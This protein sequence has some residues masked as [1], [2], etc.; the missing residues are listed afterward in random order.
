MGKRKD[1][2]KEILMNGIKKLAQEGSMVERFLDFRA[3]FHQYSFRNQLMILMQKPSATFVKG[4]RAWQEEGRQVQKGESGAL[5]WYPKFKTADE[6]YAN[7]HSHVE[8]GDQVLYGFGTGYVFDIDQTEPIEGFDG[9]VATKQTL[10]LDSVV[11]GASHYGVYQTL[12]RVAS[13]DGYEVKDHS[14]KRDVNAAGKTKGDISFTKKV[15]RLDENLSVNARVSVLAHELIHA[16]LHDEGGDEEDAERGRREIQ[17]EG[18]AYLFCGMVGLNTSE[19]SIDYVGGYLGA[20]IKDEETIM[21]DIRGEMDTITKAAD[22]LFEKTE[23]AHAERLEN[24]Q[25]EIEKAQEG[26]LGTP[27][28]RAGHPDS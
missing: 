19:S 9:E 11:K 25:T 13:H 12:Q 4:Y 22:R 21:K 16:D 10:G 23:T 2:A 17:A 26:V 14:F 27:A 15:I 3:R 28:L 20:G 5:I 1:E 6:E 24:A 7:E 8:E 18:A